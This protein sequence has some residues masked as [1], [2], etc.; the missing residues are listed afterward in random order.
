MRDTGWFKS[1][2]SSTASDNCVEVRLS[3]SGARVRDSK[4]PAAV[5]AVDVPAMVAVVK[6]GLLDR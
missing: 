2:F 1:T 3:D 4:N 5:L 6:A